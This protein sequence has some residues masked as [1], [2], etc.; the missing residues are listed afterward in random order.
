MGILYNVKPFR[1]KEKPYVDVL[2][3]SLNNPTRLMMGW[4]MVV[5]G[6][7]TP[8]S[9]LIAYWMGGAFLMGVKRFAEYRF[10][11]DSKQAT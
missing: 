5:D 8:L 1:T 9:A 10:I 6:P 7:L 2:S 11:N 4:F 3:E